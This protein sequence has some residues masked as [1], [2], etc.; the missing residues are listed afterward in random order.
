MRRKGCDRVVGSPGRWQWL[1]MRARIRTTVPC[2]AVEARPAGRAGALVMAVFTTSM[3]CLSTAGTSCGRA[4]SRRGR[5]LGSAA[6]WQEA[7]GMA[8]CRP[9]GLTGLQTADAKPIQRCA[10]NMY[11]DKVRH[12]HLQTIDS[13]SAQQCMSQ[14]QCAARRQMRALDRAWRAGASRRG[15]S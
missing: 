7:A 14:Q 10:H 11:S 13:S 1:Q 8:G 6:H 15:S 4:L 3:T 9:G 2:D 5:L 12:I